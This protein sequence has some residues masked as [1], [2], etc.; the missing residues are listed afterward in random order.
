M[1]SPTAAP[2]LDA[3]P[4]SKQLTAGATW[5]TYNGVNAWSAPGGDTASA[6]VIQPLTLEQ[7]YIGSWV[8]FDVSAVAQ[9][10][11]RD[12]SKNLGLLIKAHD[13]SASNVVTFS[14]A[15]TATAP[16]L[17]RRLGV[18]SGHRA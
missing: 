10:W 14:G 4:L 16:V 17:A 1:S 12:P 8:S 2:Q 9:S 15:P 6:P 11:L 7:S 13:E 3:A 5:N 18:A